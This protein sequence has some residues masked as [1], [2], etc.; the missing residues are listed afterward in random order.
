MGGVDPSIRALSS[1]GGM[2]N[3]HVRDYGGP[4]LP[5]F[6]FNGTG[7]NETVVKGGATVEVKPGAVQVMVKGDADAGTARRLR[8]AGD[9]IAGK[10]ARDLVRAL[11]A[12]SA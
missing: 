3:P 1:P 7:R 9:E 8:A 12:G 5:G 2:L 11:D 4:L 10:V 6:T